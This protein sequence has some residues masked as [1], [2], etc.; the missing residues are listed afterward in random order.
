MSQVST[1]LT[2]VTQTVMLLSAYRAASITAPIGHCSN[3]YGTN[4]FTMHVFNTRFYDY[5]VT[6]S[7]LIGKAE[8][9]VATLSKTALDLPL[10]VPM[11]FTIADIQS[12]QCHRSR[13]L[14][15]TREMLNL[16]CSGY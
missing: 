13:M 12:V 14:R 4:I 15:K 8:V 5:V 16:E 3:Y 2:K 7:H 11:V 6:L 10:I 9:I 1:T